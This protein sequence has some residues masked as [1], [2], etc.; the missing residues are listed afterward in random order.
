MPNDEVRLNI[1]V[2]KTFDNLMREVSVLKAIVSR[3][4]TQVRE[5]EEVKAKSSL[6]FSQLLGEIMQKVGELKKEESM[7]E[8]ANKERLRNVSNT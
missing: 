6:M 7:K 1:D 3:L 8:A 2:N 5:L 4:D